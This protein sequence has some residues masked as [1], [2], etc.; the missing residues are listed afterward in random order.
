MLFALGWDIYLFQS[1]L[2][3]VMSSKSALNLMSEILKMNVIDSEGVK[4]EAIIKII[5]RGALRDFK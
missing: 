5:T 1:W 4:E 3:G 2:L